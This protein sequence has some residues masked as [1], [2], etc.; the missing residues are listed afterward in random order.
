MLWSLM[1]RAVMGWFSEV[2][3]KGTNGAPTTPSNSWISVVL[4]PKTD[5]DVVVDDLGSTLGFIHDFMFC[6]VLLVPLLLVKISS[7]MGT[8]STVSSPSSRSRLGHSFFIAVTNQR[9]D[10][11]IMYVLIN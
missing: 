3:G 10:N 4:P 11:K 7:G 6:H 8:S 5:D 9:A 1:V 2:I